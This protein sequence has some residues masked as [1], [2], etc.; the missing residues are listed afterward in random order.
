MSLVRAR[1]RGPAGFIQ[2]SMPHCPHFKSIAASRATWENSLLPANQHTP[3]FKPA[4]EVAWP[5]AFVHRAPSDIDA[6]LD[7]RPR[8]RALPRLPCLIRVRCSRRFR[9]LRRRCCHCRHGGGCAA[10]RQ[11]WQ[12][13][14]HDGTPETDPMPLA[15]FRG[16]SVVRTLPS[17]PA[18]PSSTAAVAAP[19]P[20]LSLASLVPLGPPPSPSPSPQPSCGLPLFHGQR[21]HRPRRPYHWMGWLA[22]PLARWLTRLVDV[23]SAAA[24]TVTVVEIIVSRGGRR[25]VEGVRPTKPCFPARTVVPRPLLAA[26][27]TNKK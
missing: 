20:P 16:L 27:N 18:A 2:V 15:L 26:T 6:P 8:H 17:P 3:R 22:R 7:V 19:L 25:A 23:G 13:R 14:V 5:R 24:A 10:G 11:S 21:R 1:G 9:S 12:C 4:D